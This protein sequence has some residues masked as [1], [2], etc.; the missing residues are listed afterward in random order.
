MGSTTLFES[1]R[2]NDRVEKN[3]S[4]ASDFAQQS[5]D[6]ELNRCEVEYERRYEPSAALTH[7]GFAP[8]DPDDDQ[9]D[10]DAGRKREGDERDLP[11]MRIGRSK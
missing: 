1:C 5:R 9:T 2:R 3:K 8:I 6:Q 11:K 7:D 10:S 4:R